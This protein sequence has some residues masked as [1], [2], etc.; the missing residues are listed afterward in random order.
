MVQKEENRCPPTENVYGND[1]AM[2]SSD[3]RMITN[4]LQK[5]MEDQLEDKTATMRSEWKKNRWIEKGL[6]F[7]DKFFPNKTCYSFEDAHLAPKLAS[8]TPTTFTSAALGPLVDVSSSSAALTVQQVI[9]AATRSA[10]ANSSPSEA[11]LAPGTAS[12]PFNRCELGQRERRKFKK[13]AGNPARLDP[14]SLEYQQLRKEA[15]KNFAINAIYKKEIL[16]EKLDCL[17]HPQNGPLPQQVEFP[18]GF[19]IVTNDQSSSFQEEGQAVRSSV[20][21]QFLETS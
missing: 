8:F 18:D 17:Y 19:R 13:A 2:Y 5:E 15:D 16:K 21:V 6:R 9:P 3:C 1:F 11:H 20:H 12:H 7:F 14:T 4:E 10:T